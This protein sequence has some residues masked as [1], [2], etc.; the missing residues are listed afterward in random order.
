MKSLYN[1]SNVPHVVHCMPKNP[2]KYFCKS[3]LTQFNLYSRVLKSLVSSQ[4]QLIVREVENGGKRGQRFCF[5]STSIIIH[6]WGALLKDRHV[7]FWPPG[8]EA[9]NRN[10]DSIEFDCFCAYVVCFNVETCLHNFPTWII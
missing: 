5:G 1:A 8:S 2:S 9:G 10:K 3:C 6:K 7:V 4:C